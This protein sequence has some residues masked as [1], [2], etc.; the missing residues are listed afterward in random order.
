MNEYAQMIKDGGPIMLV[1]ALCALIALFIFLE[2]WLHFYRAQV[3]VDDLI[4]G[5]IN[6]LR[7][8]EKSSSPR[9][10]EVMV[11]AI[12]LCDTTPGPVA[13]VLAS[14]IDAY[15]NG[16]DIQQSLE[17]QSIIE[18]HRLESHLNILAT[19]TY[20]VPLL[21][22][23]GTITGIME[24]FRVMQGNNFVTMQELSSGVY[25]AL[26]STAASLCVAIPCHI[27][28]NYLLSKVQLFCIE[29]ERASSSILS[30]FQHRVSG[31]V[32]HEEP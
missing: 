21:G 3:K 14:A 2:K 23:L 20:I 15:Q 4:K 30:F 27:A 7:R 13:R 31:T 24:A 18:V 26:V 17:D 1:I 19:I 11:E 32:Q 5:L 25:R 8:D 10:K 12:A 6:V 16:D 29:M 9:P 22:L 28:Y